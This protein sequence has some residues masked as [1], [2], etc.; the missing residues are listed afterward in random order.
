MN[1]NDYTT[2]TERFFRIGA[3]LAKGITLM[4][5]HPAHNEVST[6]TSQLHSNPLRAIR[7]KQCEVTVTFTGSDDETDVV[8]YLRRVGDAAPRDIQRALSLSKASVFRRLNKLVTSGAVKKSCNT[9]A[10][11]YRAV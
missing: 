10:I 6:T 8:K 4:L 2:R 3:L 9:T 11:R 1:A 7:R 5:T